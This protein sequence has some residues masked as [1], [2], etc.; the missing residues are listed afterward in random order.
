MKGKRK[1]KQ[2]SLNPDNFV[3]A[4]EGGHFC[5]SL[6]YPFGAFGHSRTR[7]DE[8]ARAPLQFRNSMKYERDREEKTKQ[9]N[10]KLRKREKIL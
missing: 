5:A 9:E 7:M 1:K 6:C 4:T 3:T 10:R 2:K 8:N